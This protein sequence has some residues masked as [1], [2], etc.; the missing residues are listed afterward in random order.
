[1]AHFRDIQGRSP[2]H[3]NHH[4]LTTSC[5]L[6]AS[7]WSDWWCCG[8][9]PE[10]LHRTVWHPGPHGK[11]GI[12]SCWILIHEYPRISTIH[13]IPEGRAASESCESNVSQGSSGCDRPNVQRDCGGESEAGQWRQSGKLLELLELLT[14]SFT[15]LLLLFASKICGRTKSIALSVC[16]WRCK[17]QVK[18]QLQRAWTSLAVHVL[19][20]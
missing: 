13:Q 15:E 12:T 7:G 17:C 4:N 8:F 9:C 1:M 11:M 20:H 6:G 10:D 16:S 14:W 18:M 3:L 5:S 19:K 2:I